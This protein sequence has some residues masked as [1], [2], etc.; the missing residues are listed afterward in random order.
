VREITDTLA[1]SATITEVKKLPLK[2]GEEDET[3]EILPSRGQNL[4]A[5]LIFSPFS[6]R[7]GGRGDGSPKI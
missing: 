1:A 3:E 7:E 2:G 6:K 5:P 4:L